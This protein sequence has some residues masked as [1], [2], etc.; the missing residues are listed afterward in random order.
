MS[1]KDLKKE[2]LRSVQFALLLLVAIVIIG[3]FGYMFIEKYSF[4]DAFF[5]T[6]ITMSTVGFQVIKPLTPAG[7]IFTSFLIVISFGIFAYAVTTLTRYIVDGIFRHYFMDTKIRNRIEKLKNHAIVCGYGRN[8]KQSVE[9]IIKHKM[10]AV[11][12]DDKES[13]ID[14]IRK[15]PNLLYVQ[16]DATNDETLENANIKNA[17]ALITA[18]PNDA[19]NLFVVLTARELNPNLKIISRAAD[20]QSV[21]KL[22]SAGA[23]N[24]IM[25]DSIGGQRMA[26]LVTQPDV[27]EFVDYIMLPTP[28]E[29][30]IEEVSCQNMDSCL[31]EKT[32]GDWAIRQHT[33]ANII[34]LKTTDNKFVVNPT[35]DVKISSYDQLFVLGTADQ[36]KKLKDVL[37]GKLKIE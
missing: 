28:D 31:A 26:K 16:G 27:I 34:G 9:E 22:K 23:T 8:G 10:E 14:D 20:A 33:G 6:I 32:I 17:K 18:L 12:V 5:M 30:Y 4:A 2:G 15:H 24:V 37:T 3:I 13:I 29:V 36:I 7:Q 35:P 25:P 11:I 19:D 21:K 1:V